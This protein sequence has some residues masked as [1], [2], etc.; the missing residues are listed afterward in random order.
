MFV[1]SFTTSF[2]LRENQTKFKSWNV[3]F[4]LLSLSENYYL[5]FSFPSF[6]YFSFKDVWNSV[7]ASQFHSVEELK[8]E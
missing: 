5:Y 1:I 3:L 4:H 7:P 8:P 6:L 2:D